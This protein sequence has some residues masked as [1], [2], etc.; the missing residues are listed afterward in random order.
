MDFNMRII[1]DNIAYGGYGVGRIDGKTVFVDYAVPGDQLDVEIYDDRKN[2]SFATITEILEPSAKRVESPCANFGICG[3][4]SY[5][6]VGYSDEIEFKTSILQD[7]LKRIASV[8][9]YPEIKIIS[10]ER[11]HYRS[12][13]GIKC[14]GACCGFYKKNSNNIIPFP[15]SGCLLISEN[16]IDGIKKLNYAE[17][18]GDLKVAEDW[19]GTFFYDDLNRIMIEER[20]GEY[21]YRRGINSFFQS[22]KFL[23]KQMIDLVCSYSELSEGD[24]FADICAGCGFFT[25][26]LSG[27]SSNGTGYDIDKE[28][29][30]YA[31]EN[32]SLNNCNG[33]KF[34]SVSESD[35]NPVRLN[36]KT[37][38]VDPPR[39]G[40][41][42]KGRRTIN[43]INPEII[44]YISC[45]PSTYSRD[46]ADFIK[47]G[48]IPDQIT[49]IDMFPCTH[50]IEIVSRLVKKSYFSIKKQVNQSR[51]E[52]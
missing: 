47:N 39:S 42:K 10:D 9:D 18:R 22:N 28:S 5:L 6:N 27:K 49:F 34:F 17:M 48:Y 21:R 4:C 13:S 3:G 33:L 32:A 35:I 40:I 46:I 15:D 50:H 7:Q 37:V 23:R 12:H 8:S 20:T 43:A 31:R 16:L 36:P 44:V 51:D 45:N 11:Y 26:P 52:V 38:V 1:I 41:S 24:E 14:D 30:R 19:R 2:F 25:I 29:I